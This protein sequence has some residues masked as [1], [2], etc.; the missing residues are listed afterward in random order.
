MPRRGLPPQHMLWGKNL[1]PAAVPGANI[2]ESSRTDPIPLMRTA[3]VTGSADLRLT[4]EK[5][6]SDPYSVAE[7]DRP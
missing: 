4:P 2:M 1:N 6:A 7:R 5:P 3:V